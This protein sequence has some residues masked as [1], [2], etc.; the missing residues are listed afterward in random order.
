[1]IVGGVLTGVIVGVVT[2]FG[3]CA[4]GLPPPLPPELDVSFAVQSDPPGAEIYVDGKST[5]LMTPTQLTGW[6]FAQEHQVSIELRGYYPEHRKVATGLHPP[7]LNVQL[8]RIAHLTA[9]TLPVPAAVMIDGEV[10]GT[11]SPAEVDLPADRDLKLVV[12]ADGFVTLRRALRLKP[13][14]SDAH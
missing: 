11:N 9:T 2:M 7:D 10:V 4:T 3:S 5:G 8:P 14:E 6:D 1:M 12:R 13:D